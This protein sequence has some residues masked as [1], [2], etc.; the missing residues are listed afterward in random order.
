[1]HIEN[2]VPERG[3]IFENLLTARRGFA[4][5]AAADNFVYSAQSYEDV[6]Y[7]CKHCSNATNCRYYINIDKADH[8]P[9]QAAD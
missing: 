5:T 4:S 9:V 8:A 1:V 6:D 7:A 2:I 3:T